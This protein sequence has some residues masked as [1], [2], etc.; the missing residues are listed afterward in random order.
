MSQLPDLA[1]IGALL[2]DQSRAV[3]LA[4]LMDGR[5]LTATELAA[6]AGIAP[7][8]AS[9]HLAKLVGGRLLTVDVQGRHRYFRI[10]SAEIADVLEAL[11]TL[12]P[13]RPRPGD[14]VEGMRFA[15]SCYDHLAGLLAVRVRQGL[16]D[17]GFLVED[18]LEH[19]LT[20]TG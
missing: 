19:H 8:T 17:H 7:P 12:A 5:A 1:S 18:G 14:A 2:G 6:R 11:G 10:P 4:E 16:L 15:R 9:E 20:P 13:R 3:I